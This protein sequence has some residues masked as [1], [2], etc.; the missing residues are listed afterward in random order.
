MTND[1]TSQRY[2]KA[3][4][5][6]KELKSTGRVMENAWSKDVFIVEDIKL[7]ETSIKFRFNDSAKDYYTHH[8]NIISE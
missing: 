4:N 6:Y 3:F 2:S 8:S 5:K 1:E 7:F